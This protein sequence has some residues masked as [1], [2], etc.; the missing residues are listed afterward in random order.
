MLAVGS[1]F[2]YGSPVG[3]GFGQEGRPRWWEQAHCKKPADRRTELLQGNPP[4]E[5]T[6]LK[7]ASWVPRPKA[8]TS[9][10][11]ADRRT[12]RLRERN[13]DES[14]YKPLALAMGCLTKPRTSACRF[15]LLRMGITV[16]MPWSRFSRPISRAVDEA[17][18]DQQHLHHGGT[19][20]GQEGVQERPERCRFRFLLPQHPHADHH[21]SLASR[22]AVQEQHRFVAA[23]PAAASLL[24]LRHL[25]FLAD[26]MVV[27]VEEQ[28]LRA[29]V[30]RVVGH[31][32]VGAVG[33]EQAI[34]VERPE[35]LVHGGDV[36]VVPHFELLRLG[37][38]GQLAEE[39]LI[40]GG[41]AGIE[42]AVIE[43]LRIRA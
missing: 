34:G 5:E 6:R 8:R 26:G 16:S 23:S 9:C 4:V 12:R 31:E 2:G 30:P 25:L 21:E 42:V 11:A 7:T 10:Q 22:V 43:A 27:L 37:V 15:M 24:G 41:L 32:Q 17:T 33:K 29:L 14:A 18:V 3:T 40:A 39:V 36:A 38:A 13:P 19:H 28:P 20:G 1:K 35:F